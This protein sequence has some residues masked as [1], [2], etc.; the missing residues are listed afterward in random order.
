[1]MNKLST[2]LTLCVLLLACCTTAFAL[3]DDEEAA[4]KNV[5]PPDAWVFPAHTP[6]RV[7]AVRGL[8]YDYY[9][10]ERALARLGGAYITGSWHSPG[11]VRYY[12]ESYDL[13]MRHHLIVVGNVN[14]DAFGP[15]RRKMLKDYVEQGGSVLLL[16]GKF[17]FG[18]QYHGNAL[19]EISPVTFAEAPI[20]WVWRTGC[21]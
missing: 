17:A 14:G 10:I 1:M 16:G 5:K 3:S 4:K 7:L 9:G 6:L 20:C 21:R 12:P 11:S 2:L 18:K 19:E 13:L 8:W 15:L